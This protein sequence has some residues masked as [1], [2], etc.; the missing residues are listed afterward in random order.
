V[1]IRRGRRRRSKRMRQAEQAKHWRKSGKMKGCQHEQPPVP[2]DFSCKYS[3]MDLERI[4]DWV[5]SNVGALVG[6]TFIFVVLSLLYIN[7]KMT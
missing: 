2:S 5:I 6:I 7:N 1:R 4:A 3:R